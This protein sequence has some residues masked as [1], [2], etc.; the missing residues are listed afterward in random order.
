MYAVYHEHIPAYVVTWISSWFL[1][2]I[3]C[4]SHFRRTFG[5]CFFFPRW[6]GGWW[7]QSN[8]VIH[9]LF[10]YA[11]SVSRGNWGCWFSMQKTL[12]FVRV[13]PPFSPIAIPLSPPL[14]MRPTDFYWPFRA[15]SVPRFDF[16]PTAFRRVWSRRHF[17]KETKYF[18]FLGDFAPE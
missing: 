12:N 8:K 9:Q 1:S 14:A 3:R 13:I 16:Q 15:A 5:S 11:G 6:S 4:I 18:R 2:I 17:L 7:G 10:I